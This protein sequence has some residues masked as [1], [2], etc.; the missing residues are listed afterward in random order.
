MSS[1]SDATKRAHAAQFR[2]VLAAILGLGNVGGTMP[3]VDLVARTWQ[4]M[5]RSGAPRDYREALAMGASECLH[6]AAPLV[7]RESDEKVFEREGAGWVRRL[8]REPVEETARLCPHEVVLAVQGLA[9]CVELEQLEADRETL[10]KRESDP[11]NA[12]KFYV[13][14]GSE[15]GALW[16][17]AYFFE[18]DAEDPKVSVADLAWHDSRLSATMLTAEQADLV[19]AHSVESENRRCAAGQERLFFNP[20]RVPVV[21]KQTAEETAK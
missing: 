1:K 8:W 12:D 6:Y 5:R 13:K 3:G 15:D 14:C 21:R 18:G 11:A 16:A 7:E 19:V 9:E 17:G 20:R 2:V 10:R 4:D